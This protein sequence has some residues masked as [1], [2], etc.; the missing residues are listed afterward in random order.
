MWL[1]HDLRSLVYE[2]FT[3]MKLTI[4][5]LCLSVLGT[6]AMDSY[7]QTTRLTV[8]FEQT[9]IKRILNEIEDQSEYRFFYSGDVNVE[10][11]ASIA[12]EN[13][14][15]DE[16]LND[17]FEGSAVKYRIKG[18]QI[19]LFVEENSNTIRF[20]VQPINVSGKV[21]DG[22]GLPLPGVSVIIKGTTSGTTTNFD[23]IYRLKDVSSDKI[24]VFS[25]VGMKSQEIQ[26]SGK[27]NIDI[28]MQEEAIGLE[29]LIVVGYG[30][31]KKVNLTGAISQISSDKLENRPI[32]SSA[33]GL[34]GL[35]P[36]LNITFTS[37]E[38]GNTG[39]NF[40][41]RGGTSINGGSPLILI[42]GVEQNIELINPNDIA[43]VTVLKDAASAAIYGARAAFGVILVTTKQAEKDKPTRITYSGQW[44]WSKAT[45]MPELIDNSYDYAVA[46]NKAMNSF[47]GSQAFSDQHIEKIKA[48]HEDP[49]NNP[50]WEEIDDKFYFYGHSDW[51]NELIND[52]APTQQHNVK[53]SGGGKKTS[54]YTSVGYLNQEGIYK[55]G[56]DAFE[57]YNVRF[58]VNNEVKDWLDINLRIA[59]NN[60]K[61]DKPHVYKSDANYINSIVFSRPTSPLVYPGEREEFQGLQFANPA[62]YQEKAG[63]DSYINHDLWMTS[64]FVFKI[65][66]NFKINTDF[67]YQNYSVNQQ[68]NATKIKFMNTGFETYYGETGND[69]VYLSNFR[70]N[71]Y[72]VNVYGQYENHF[73][74]NH[75]VK[76]MIGYN[77]EWRNEQSF[78]AQRKELI[79][80]KIPAINLALGDQTV[81]GSE[82]EYAIRGA[83]YRLNYIYKDRYM[84]EFNG[85]YDG[86]SRF[87]KSDRFGFFPSVSAGWR[88][89]EEEFMKALLPSIDNLKIRASYGSLGNQKTNSYYEYIA[90]M[91]SGQTSRYLFNGLPSLYIKPP[92]LIPESLTWEKITSQG[93][94]I[95]LNMFNNRLGVVFDKYTRTTSDMLM[96]KSY[97]ELLGT[98]APF[99]NA[100]E[101]KTKGWEVAVR[102]N[103]KI[104]KDF[105]YGVEL[106]MSDYETEI[107]KFD[108]PT[109]SL[110][111]WYEGRKF[112][113]IWGYET[114]G[115]FQ[116]EGEVNAHADQ[117]DIAI[118]WK[119]GDIMYKD[120]LT[121]D[122]DGDGIADTG[123]GEINKGSYT[124]DDRGDLEIIGNSTPRYS[125]GINLNASYKNFFASVFFQGI[126]KRDFWPSDGLF[127]PFATQ[128]YQIQT[129]FIP[130]S[131]S[132]DNPDAYFGRLLARDSRNR[133]VQSKYIQDASYIRLK[134][135]T[136]GYNIPRMLIQKAGFVSGK[137]FVSGQ[138]LWE[139]SN[140]GKPYDP[141]GIKTGSGLLYPFQKTYSVGI[142]LTF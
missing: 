139:H 40:N 46:V 117:S 126:G 38:P 32:T 120:Q 21:T 115:I 4:L 112:G 67:S 82:A 55:K 118:N 87:K 31:Q 99:E 49:N 68:R 136:V 86:T 142:N 88:I 23:G 95:D 1:Y 129:H 94:G 106:S 92:K 114:E 79:S 127:W 97:P 85:R 45:I 66:N 9:S 83:F 12:L 101:L 25:F 128:W 137:V 10:K 22:D 41:I 133:Q 105:K 17:I 89:S 75:Y 59:Y 74:E 6:W 71:H 65:T 102:W 51:K 63:R 122:T 39:T 43:N 61:T 30:T 123:D 64:E 14:E 50:E 33:Q 57:R 15:V 96:R 104:G 18:R 56:T 73:G 11:K 70:R 26:I 103:D 36:N 100:A 98:S 93:Y 131:W 28:M 35:I 78:S 90:E 29:E 132:A 134:N 138:N 84:V 116:N 27:N 3:R 113:E 72:A 135:L 19:A 54:Y 108:N 42:D 5:L 52:F 109:G 81:N 48:Y 119:P 141:E 130:N 16:I 77:Q 80:D 76:G 111:T 7:S 110:S 58:N 2:I 107:T 125:Y 20:A 34:Q 47:D 44:S 69:Y 8:N 24:L 37:G 124:L 121:V 140:V 62:T 60:K 13:K 91:E 53:V